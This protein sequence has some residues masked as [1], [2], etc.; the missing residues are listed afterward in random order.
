MMPVHR[1]RL[2]AGLVFIAIA[3]AF[4]SGALHRY[5]AGTAASMGPGYFPLLLSG[6]LLLL[7]LAALLQALRLRARAHP[8]QA[9]Q[10]PRPARRP[11]V[12]VLLANIAFGV[13]LTG[14][15]ALGIAAQGLV[16]SIYAVTF[17]ASLARPAQRRRETFVLAT[18]LAAGCYL[19]FIQGLGLAV[20]AWPSF[21]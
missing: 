20:P 18:V 17:I 14:V 4:G 7:G 11:V 5:P 12:F 19:I 3:L 1:Q 15:P 9:A 10:G 6:L 8:L 13:L 21:P 16:I 2:Y